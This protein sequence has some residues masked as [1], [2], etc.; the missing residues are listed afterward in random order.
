MPFDFAKAIEA[1][2]NAF[3]SVS[4]CFKT[5]KE[6]QCETQILK[7]KK[8]LKEATNVAEQIFEITDDYKDYFNY[9]DLEDYEKLRKKFDEKN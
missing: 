9:R 3:K 1:V 2:G 7:D 6:H 5:S 4:D 8:R